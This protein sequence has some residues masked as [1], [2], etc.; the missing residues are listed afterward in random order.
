M[1]RSG[2]VNAFLTITYVIVLLIYDKH[3]YIWS[4]V[5]VL[6]GEGWRSILANPHATRYVLVYPAIFLSELLGAEA[7]EVFSWYVVFLV[8][9]TARILAV[10]TV[11]ISGHKGKVAG[12]WYFL[13]L[14]AYGAVTFFMNGRL[15]FAF[16]G[17]SLIMFAQVRYLIAN[18][19]RVATTS[20]LFL[21]GLF[22]T[23]VSSGTLAVGNGII[24]LF[25]LALGISRFPRIRVRDMWLGMIVTLFLLFLVGPFLKIFI[26]KNLGFY[27]GSVVNMLSH[28]YGAILKLSGGDLGV[29]I[30]VM[31]T[32]GFL[33]LSVL[34]LVLKLVVQRSP[35]IAPLCINAAAVFVGVFGWSAAATA[36]TGLMPLIFLGVRRCAMGLLSR[37]LHFQTATTGKS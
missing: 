32:A 21:L 5:T 22:F 25:L 6:M 26:K 20:F 9:L 14:L 27:G 12:N 33:L 4:Q 30:A 24:V 36:L 17:I 1:T 3:F 2:Y 37:P 13:Y 31:M 34:P 19:P 16:L 23:S 28:G 15:A 11:M 35:L 10:T 18:V 8:I 7:N 29:I